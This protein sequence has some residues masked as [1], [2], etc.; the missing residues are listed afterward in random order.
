MENKE[1]ETISKKIGLCTRDI[2][3]YY[4]SPLG[5]IVVAVAI[6]ISGLLGSNYLKERE[7]FKARTEKSYLTVEALRIYSELMSKRE[8]A[9]SAL[10][11]GMFNTIIQ[12]FSET[13]KRPI[14]E[15]ILNLKLLAY[16]FD[17]SF[18]IKPFFLFLR[19][20]ELISSGMSRKEYLEDL[21]NIAQYVIT[22]Q[23]WSL[24]GNGAS[25]FRTVDL[26]LLHQNRACLLLKD[27]TLTLE[28]RER[29]FRIAVLEVNTKMKE[30]KVR[31]EIRTPKESD[32]VLDIKVVEF[33]VGPFDFPAVDN[34]RLSHDQRC[35]IVLNQLSETAAHITFVIFPGA[36]AGIKEK[37]YYQETVQ[38]ILETGEFLSG[39]GSKKIW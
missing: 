34:I 7:A 29:N 17:E 13:E 9:E 1:P 24:G 25:F 23:L 19:N 31:L 38:H 10:R 15:L 35:A 5:S 28:G 27:E 22:K 14:E 2:I 36:L 8:E 26:D 37:P 30:I 12:S 32:H 16:N 20:K 33:W 6:G 39:E 11:E 4:I 18:N 21:E 3:T